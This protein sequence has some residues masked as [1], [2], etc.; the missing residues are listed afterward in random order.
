M[1]GEKGGN[2]G[3]MGGKGGGK[4]E[5]GRREEGG[6]E[7]GGETYRAEKRWD[8]GKVRSICSSSHHVLVAFLAR[9]CA[10]IR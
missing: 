2:R 10:L 9:V 4:R 8:G 7:G 6:S 5:G 1:E 3:N